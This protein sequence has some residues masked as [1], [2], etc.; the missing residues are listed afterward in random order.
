MIESQKE[1]TSSTVKFIMLS[2]YSTDVPDANLPNII[3]QYKSKTFGSVPVCVK[4]Q[5]LVKDV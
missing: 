1:D 3:I 5:R 4:N 2:V